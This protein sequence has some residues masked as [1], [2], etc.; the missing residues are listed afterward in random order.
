MNIDLKGKRVI[1]TGASRGIGLAIA[2]AFAREGARVAICARS[3]EAVDAAAETLRESAE[4][5][6]ARVVDVTDTKGV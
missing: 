6:L 2:S 1:V 5:V 3:Q 4:Q